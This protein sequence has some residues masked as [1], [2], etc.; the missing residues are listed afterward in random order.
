MTTSST[1]TSDPVLQAFPDYANPLK[2]AKRIQEQRQD[3]GHLLE[4]IVSLAQ[5]F[6]GLMSYPALLLTRR[7]LGERMLKWTVLVP[8]W[9]LLALAA[10][11]SQL[12]VGTVLVV[13]LPAVF[14]LHKRAAARC[15]RAGVRHYSY[16]RGESVLSGVSALKRRLPTDRL[17][18]LLI[19]ALAALTIGLEAFLPAAPWSDYL[20][21]AYDA[22][23]WVLPAYLG[24]AALCLML[25]EANLRRRDR[26]TLLDHIDQQ[27]MATYFAES[28]DPQSNETAD[29]GFSVAG[30]ADLPVLRQTAPASDFD[31]VEH[32]WDGLLDPM[33]RHDPDEALVRA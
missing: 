32:G 26:N 19:V 18:P 29:E 33:P 2:L 21:R 28:L 4:L 16:A 17:D 9:L 22:V 30:I 10:T 5:A 14:L 23:P 1:T 15:R 24:T 7:R 12:A 25:V 31:A 13:L 20:P 8:A 6:G 11:A 27:I 3:L